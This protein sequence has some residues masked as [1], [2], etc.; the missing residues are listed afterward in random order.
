MRWWPTKV[1]LSQ[2]RCCSPSARTARRQNEKEVIAY[3]FYPKT[4]TIH[5]TVL[6]NLKKPKDVNLTL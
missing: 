2:L 4:V 3:G 6:L 5:D 1:R